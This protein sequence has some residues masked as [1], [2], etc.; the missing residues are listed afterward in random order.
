M[1]DEMRLSYIPAMLMATSLLLMAASSPA[2]SN[3]TDLA[4][5]LA[6]KSQLSDPSATIANNWTT[7]ASFCSWTGV[8]C[9]RR[10]HQRVTALELPD[11][12]L[13]GEL[14]P[15]LGLLKEEDR[16]KLQAGVKRLAHAAAAL[17]DRS[18]PR[19]RLLLRDRDGLQIG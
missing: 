13:H 4:P 9:S 14:S 15:H 19:D 3:S 12:P 5:L 18:F 8:S 16:V 10:H 1:R 17:T 2:P 7:Y 11:I 6:F